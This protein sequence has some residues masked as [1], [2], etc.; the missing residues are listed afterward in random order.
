MKKRSIKYII[1]FIHFALT[2]FFEK[3]IFKPGEYEAVAFSIPMNWDYSVLFEQRIVYGIAKIM[4]GILIFL[5]WKL[6]FAT[7]EGKIPKTIIIIFSIIWVITT[8]VTAIGWPDN[9]IVWDNLIVYSYALRLVP[10][11]WHSVYMT[12]LYA[13]LLMTIPHPFFISVFQCAL[14]AFS[15]TYICFRIDSCEKITK[16]K[17]IRNCVLISVLFRDSYKV[18]SY[19]ARGELNVMF[20]LVFLTVILFDIIE[21]KKRE[22]TEIILMASFA[23]FLSLFRTEGIIIGILGFAIWYILIYRP[24]ILRTAGALVMMLAVYC[25]LSLPGKVGE[26]KYYGSDYLIINTI[27]PLHNI[28]CAENANINYEGANNDII[29]INEIVPSEIICEYG[30]EG[31]RSYNYL[32]GRRDFNQ[33]LAGEEKSEAYLKAYRN[34]IIHN[35]PIFLKTQTGLVIS[36]FESGFSPYEEIYLGMHNELP[37]FGYDIWETG[38]NDIGASAG[39]VAW[40]END[41]RNSALKCLNFVCNKYNSL[42]VKTFAYLAFILAEILL[43]IYIVIKTICDVLKKN[44]SLLG[45]GMVALLLCCYFGA[46]WLTIPTDFNIYFHAYFYCT[47]IVEAIYIALI[48]EKKEIRSE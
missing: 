7:I 26:I 1:P 16:K 30:V 8:L 32:Q 41:I 47:Y 33:S 34:L 24:K 37:A 5:I 27:V 42:W 2:F 20:T 35:V 44:Y 45:V 48:S 25:V 14:Y 38:K 36:A 12:S 23:I 10:D 19:A 28:L 6:I 9:T 46:L 18:F 39:C 21:G 29:A 4:A 43:S 11:Y 31:Y 17:W 15:I 22:K 3:M 13:A 40:T